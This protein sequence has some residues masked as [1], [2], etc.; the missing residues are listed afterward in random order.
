VRQHAALGRNIE[1]LAHVVEQHQQRVRAL[2]AVGCRIDSDHRVTGAEQQA[3]EDAGSD[4]AQAVGRVI[5]LQPHRQA[6]GQSERV[7]EAGDDRA[8]CGDHHQILRSADLAD[9]RR[10]LRQHAGR[11][12]GEGLRCCCVGQQPVAQA[13]HS[14]VR[15]RRKYV[16]I[17]RV[18]NQTCDLIGLVGH[19]VLFE[20]GAQR[21]VGERRLRRHPLL[22]AARCDGSQNV[23]A[24]QRRRLG[25]QRH[26][27]LKNVA[28]VSDCRAVH[29]VLPVDA[30]RRICAT[31][32]ALS[33][34]R[35][36][37]A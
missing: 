13:T 6:A 37:R 33:T 3:V 28:Y 29:I 21:K 18:D 10:H 31:N 24:A 2:R 17:V 34:T 9:R 35:V 11:K 25:E 1:L 14:Q 26:Q 16:S 30:C 36:S 8:F 7:A 27:I 32:R 4:A 12:G 19:D 22:L 5:G 15:D 20:K 23:T